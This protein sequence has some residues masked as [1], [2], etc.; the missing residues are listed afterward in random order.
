MPC[1]SASG[2]V[3]NTTRYRSLRSTSRA[4]AYGLEGSMRIC[5]SW[6]TVM[7]A[8]MAHGNQRHAGRGARLAEV[9]DVSIDGA[10]LIGDQRTHA[11][12]RLRQ[13]IYCTVSVGSR[14][15]FVTP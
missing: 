3:A 8:R 7:K 6:S 1:R 10:W 15:R 11:D 12:D 4:I 9:V 2:S 14:D 13:L 5:P